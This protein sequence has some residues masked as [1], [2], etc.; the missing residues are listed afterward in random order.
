MS[1]TVV[2]TGVGSG[3]GAALVRKCVKEGCQV[4]MF[5]RSADYLA[6]LAAEVK[7]QQGSAL[8]VPTDITNRLALLIF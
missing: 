4:G 1:Q 3:L 6:Q 8:S 5:A 2:I 7:G